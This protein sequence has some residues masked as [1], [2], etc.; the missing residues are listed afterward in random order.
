MVLEHRTITDGSQPCILNE[1]NEVLQ[2]GEHDKESSNDS[3][4]L[5]PMKDMHIHVN[6]IGY[7]KTSEKPFLSNSIQPNS[8]PKER[9][10]DQ[11]TNHQ[12]IFSQK[13]R[14]THSRVETVKEHQSQMSDSLRLLGESRREIIKKQ[15]M[16]DMRTMQEKSAVTGSGYYMDHLKLTVCDP[17]P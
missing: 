8:N 14:S 3:E 6:S 1:E 11:K 2:S 7:E 9:L 12:R 13:W 16:S 15:S 17:S 4:V 5:I 10:S